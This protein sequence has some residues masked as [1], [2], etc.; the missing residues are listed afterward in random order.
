M[1]RRFFLLLKNSKKQRAKQ[2]TKTLKTASQPLFFPIVDLI[3]V[4]R[5]KIFAG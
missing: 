5:V 1:F 4:P 3:V 2:Q